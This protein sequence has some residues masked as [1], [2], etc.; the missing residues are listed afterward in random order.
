M[1]GPG[2]AI[3]ALAVAI[4]VALRAVPLAVTGAL[5]GS[6]LLAVLSIATGTAAYLL[7][8]TIVLRGGGGPS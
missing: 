5:S 3:A 4:T 6:A 2:Y 1:L 8:V 7:M